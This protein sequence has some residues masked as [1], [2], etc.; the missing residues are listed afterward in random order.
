MR[1]SMVSNIWKPPLAC[2]LQSRLTPGC[3]VNRPQ[4]EKLRFHPAK[5]QRTI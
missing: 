1:V 2:C 4:S 5:N 3:A